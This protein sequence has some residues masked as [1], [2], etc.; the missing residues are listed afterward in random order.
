[1]FNTFALGHKKLS[2]P[3]EITRNLTFYLLFCS[4]QFEPFR[5][6]KLKAKEI[7]VYEYSLFAIAGPAQWSE[8]TLWSETPCT[9]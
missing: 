9:K 2:L 1:L 7:G 3:Q 8:M 4:N 5:G 6:C